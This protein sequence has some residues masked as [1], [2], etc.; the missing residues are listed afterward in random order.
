VTAAE[1]DTQTALLGDPGATGAPRALHPHVRRQIAM[2]W[3]E[4]HNNGAALSE[5]ACRVLVESGCHDVP[6]LLV[7]LDRLEVAL[8]RARSAVA[9]IERLL[10][11]T[12][13]S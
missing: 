10:I 2:R 3:S 6:A 1:P 8:L 7:E 9:D 4:H 12:L 11:R 5:A 13:E